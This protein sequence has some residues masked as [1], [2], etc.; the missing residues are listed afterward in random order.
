MIRTAGG[1]FTRSL[2]KDQKHYITYDGTAFAVL[3]LAACGEIK[4]E[5]EK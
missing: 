4:P 5:K 1:F 3:A 2:W